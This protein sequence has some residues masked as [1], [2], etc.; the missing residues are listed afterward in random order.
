MKLLTA[1]REGQGERQGDFCHAVE[2]ELVL[3]W[4]ACATDGDDPHGRCGCGRA[5]AGMSSL[6][7]TTTAVVRDLDLSRD[8]LR[9]AVEA[10]LVAAGY[11]P[12]VLG[13]EDFGDLVA[14]NGRG[15]RAFRSLVA[16]RNR[17]RPGR[18]LRPAALAAAGQQG[19]DGRVDDRQRVTQTP[20]AVTIASVRKPAI[21]P[22]S[23]P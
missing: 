2:G 15:R 10:Y 20:A 22:M 4:F 14:E 17:S 8:D 7:A 19:P 6:R 3:V 9:V 16:R 18:R 5:F 12:D 1:T 21:R 23:R 13:E 11:S